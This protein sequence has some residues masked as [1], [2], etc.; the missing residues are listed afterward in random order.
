MA[1]ELLNYLNKEYLKLHKSYES[2]FWISYMGDHSVDTKKDKALQAKDKFQSDSKLRAKVF[3]VLTE[4]KN[5]EEKEKLG[6]WLKFFDC[7]QTPDSLKKLKARIN[8]LETKMHKKMASAKEGYIDPVTKKFVKQSR[9]KMAGAQRTEGSEV[10]R[11]ALYEG[12]QK[13]AYTNIKEYI[14]YVKML[15]EYA[16]K[17]GFSDFYAY[18]IFIEEGMTKAELF[19]IFDDIYRKT[20]YAFKDIRNL[21]KEKPGLRKPWNFSYMMAGDFTKEDDQYFPFDEA[22]NRWGRSFSAM[23]IDFKGSALNLD[24]LDRKGKYANGF[25]HWPIP[26]HF[27]GSERVVGQSN[28]T[29]NVVYGQPG[30]AVQGYATLFHEGGHAAHILNSEQSEICLNTEY[31]PASTAWDETQSMFLDTVFSSIEWKSRYAK[32]KAG[33]LYPFEL[34]K[35]KVERLKILSPL[36]LMSIIAVCSFERAVYEEKNLT[37]K[38]LIQ[39]A[40]NMSNKFFDYS[41]PSLWLLSVNHIYSWGS[42]CSYHGYGLATLALTQWRE[43]FFNKYGY[44]VDNKNVGREMR[45]VW[46]LASGKTFKEFVIMATGKKLSADAW[47]K[48]VTK[49]I[50]DTLA[51][52]KQRIARLKKVPMQK[53]EIKLNAKI[54]MVSGKKVIADNTKSFEQMSDKYSKWLHS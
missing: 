41:E 35:R 31:P 8:A 16:R 15:N 40:K 33:D 7:Y 51:L 46:K 34:F 37:S 10:K 20:K 39:I 1:K 27:K 32:N 47:V 6:H 43:Y 4:T 30:A 38:K 44:I 2:L 42:V 22:L 25:C 14:Q 49:S 13:L 9:L 18:K 24:L 53:G 23:G 26:I 28:F 19:K 48:N 29:C 52:A 12:L 5:P 11:K 21:E 45:E 36:G 17:L 3:K 50:P 54:R